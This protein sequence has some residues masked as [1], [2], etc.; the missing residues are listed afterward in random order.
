MI[1]QV[2]NTP[3]AAPAEQS[4]DCAVVID[5]LRAT[6]TMAAAF[7]AG[8][9]A[10]QVFADMERLRLISDTW[11]ADKRIRLGE[12][13]GRRVE[14]C[15]LGNSPLEVEAN[16]VRGRRLFMSTT[17][18][19]RCLEAVRHAPTVI[20]AALTTRRAVVDFLIRE[21][22]EMIWLVASGW[23]GGYSAEDTVC[24]GAI[25]DGL[26][27]ST[28]GRI[29]ALAGNDAVLG[30]VALYRG[31]KERLPD[32]MRLAHHGQRLLKLGCEEDLNYCASLDLLAVVPVQKEPGVLFP[33]SDP[34]PDPD[35]R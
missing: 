22:F 18:G 2:F 8:A 30:A 17:N 25:A 3:D 34:D 31:W 28:G 13:G 29:E 32:L 19:T 12:R 23:Q 1:L 7:Q 27:C 4:P 33:A 10:I 11:P 9:E 14:G 26:I 24:A 6:S 5:V 35:V 16:R 20:T 15:D 21:R